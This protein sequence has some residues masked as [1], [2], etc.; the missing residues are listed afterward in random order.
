MNNSGMSFIDQNKSIG[1]SPLDILPAGPAIENTRPESGESF[2]DCLQRV[3]NSSVNTGDNSGNSSDKNLGQPQNSRVEESPPAPRLNENSEEDIKDGDINNVETAESIDKTNPNKAENKRS[4]N[5]SESAAQ[6]KDT[7]P[8]DKKDK[9]KKEDKRFEGDIAVVNP[10]KLNTQTIAESADLKGHT[11]PGEESP[12]RQEGIKELPNSS[13]LASKGAIKADPSAKTIAGPDMSAKTESL[14]ENTPQTTAKEQIEGVISQAV[15]DTISKKITLSEKKKAVQPPV[16]HE[17]S[18]TISDSKEANNAADRTSKDN[19]ASGRDISR[20][21]SHQ[22]GKNAPA[23]SGAT[24]AAANPGVSQEAS[25]GSAAVNSAGSQMVVNAPI[26]PIKQAEKKNDA[27]SPDAAAKIKS[28]GQSNALQ[29]P[30]QSAD[31]GTAGSARHAGDE[32]GSQFDRARFVQ[33]VERAFAAMSERGGTVRLKLSPPE[34]GSVRMEITVNK[35]VMK[36]RLEAENK[37]TKNLLLENLPGLR[38]RLAQQNIKIQKFDVDLRDPASG[39][40]PQHT[41]GQAETGSRDNG[42]RGGRPPVQI[43]TGAS[44]TVVESSPHNKHNGQLNVIV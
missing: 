23:I 8:T 29:R 1:L 35:G 5:D 14:P 20:K 43:Q 26:T 13:I 42:H 6:N 31:K 38:D 7:A 39:G 16:Q 36:A 44:A 27:Q 11:R 32:T 25:V 24:E 41:P 12:A 34:L 37:E 28:D 30:G 22:N 33:R 21:N 2:N 3:Q 19:S 4:E 9:S 17:A 15:N 40:T 18:E 10:E